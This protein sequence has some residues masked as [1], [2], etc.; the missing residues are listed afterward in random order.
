MDIE[1]YEKSK[2]ILMENHTAD[3]LFK[4]MILSSCNRGKVW[5]N[6][7]SDTVIKE[8]CLLCLLD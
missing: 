1:I 6:D 8:L 7:P 3:C 2:E 5:E 4:S